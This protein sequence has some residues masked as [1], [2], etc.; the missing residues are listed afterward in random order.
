MKTFILLFESGFTF[1]WI[2]DPRKV[3][4]AE[5]S[6]FSELSVRNSLSKEIENQLNI[7][8]LC[9]CGFFLLLVV[10]K[11]SRLC[12]GSKSFCGKEFFWSFF[13]LLLLLLLLLLFSSLFFRSL[14]EA[15][16]SD[17]SLLLSSSP[18]VPAACELGD[19]LISRQSLEA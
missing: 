14:P 16:V 1:S 7:L 10:S 17:V 6:C 19:R 12:S 9:L 5:S 2:C 15:L 3:S 4:A 13:L 18:C 11:V 8:L